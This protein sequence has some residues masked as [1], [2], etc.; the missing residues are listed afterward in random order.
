MANGKL[1]AGFAAIAYPADYGSSGIMTFITNQMGIVYQRDLGPDTEK[2]AKMIEAF[3]PSDDWDAVA[4]D[5][6][7]AKP[8]GEKK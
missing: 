5:L 2:I 3:D 1:A 6:P 4:T 8:D 7:E